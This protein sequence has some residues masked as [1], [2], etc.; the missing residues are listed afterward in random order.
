MQK[1]F[2]K[3]YTEKIWRERIPKPVCEDLP[4]YDRLYNKAWELAYAHVRH[5]P[6]MPQTPYMD[7]AFCDTQ[8]WIWDTC[9][10]TL[11]CKYA[12][13]VFPGVES[14]RNFYDVLYGGKSLPVIVTTERE[15]EWT[16]FKPGT[17]T[18][19]FVHI[20]DNP[21][22]FAF[23]EYENALFHGDK[24]YIKDLLYNRG[25]LQKHYEWF[26]NVKGP[27]TPDGVSLPT[28]LIS[29]ELGY[30]WEGGRSGMDNT[31]RTRQGDHTDAVRPNNPD[32]L[33][34]DAIC[35]QAL[36]AK[37]IASLFAL[38]GDGENAAAWEKRYEEKKTVVNTYYWD[39]TDGFYYD[40]DR[41]THDF[42]K[43]M[44]TAS[45]WAMTAGIASPERAERLV[46]QV[47]NEET[48]GGKVPLLSLARNDKNFK[49]HGEYWRGSLWLPTAYASMRG[50]VAYGYHGVAHEA[51]RRILDHMLATYDGYTPHTIWECYAPNFA[52]PATDVREK[53]VV[54]PD[55]CGWSALGPI[56]IY[57][58]NVL[59]FHTVNAFTRTV[60]WEKPAE[61]KKAVGI[62]N[63]RFGDV[64][65]D[66]V[67]EGKACTVTSNA[68]YTLK[69]CGKAYAIEAG[70][71][72]FTL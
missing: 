37:R 67:A 55:F 3:A 36:A 4:A 30:R 9:F 50:L 44:T 1:N 6:G 72:T 11:F 34:I 2:D 47:L 63:L 21:P 17:H 18:P 12:P 49:T 27:I 62:R 66:I 20:A 19:I 28:C 58:E 59:G 29:E 61:F 46:A 43:V 60:E 41:G 51:G 10:M 35:Q 26:E 15:P 14:L 33:W 32:A 64:V 8:I 69:V 38:V 16:G 22:L 53:G 52:E 5:I 40:I 57:I 42:Y 45:F 24:D 68:H 39:E 70:K 65:T 56:S 13:D 7:E 48:L 25:V 54:R 71:Q 31:P 23:A